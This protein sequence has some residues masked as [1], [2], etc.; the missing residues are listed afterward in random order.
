MQASPDGLGLDPTFE[1]EEGQSRPSAAPPAR[2]LLVM[3]THT[4]EVA[5][6][7]VP[8]SMILLLDHVRTKR[9]MPEE[10]RCRLVI[11]SDGL[12]SVYEVQE[13]FTF[14]CALE[15]ARSRGADRV[16]GGGKKTLDAVAA[17]ITSASNKARLRGQGGCGAG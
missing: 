9:S 15:L 13:E 8:F 14:G 2:W 11:P 17:G 6:A 1:D 12:I 4:M 3:A 10:I 7:K 5:T 16:A